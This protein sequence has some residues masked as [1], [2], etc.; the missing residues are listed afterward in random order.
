MDRG[1]GGAFK[2]VPGGRG[3]R[4]TIKGNAASLADPDRLTGA[5]NA[6]SGARSPGRQS[7]GSGY[8]SASR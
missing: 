7:G 2:L 4:R 8:P 1:N 5:G 3:R 6:A